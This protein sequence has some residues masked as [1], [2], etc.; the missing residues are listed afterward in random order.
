MTALRGVGPRWAWLAG[1][2]PALVVGLG[3]DQP[4]RGKPSGESCTSSR[5]SRSRVTSS[6]GRR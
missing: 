4:D 3:L 2:S 5:P 1:S 6:S